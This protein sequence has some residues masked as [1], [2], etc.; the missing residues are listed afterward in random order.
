MT[1]RLI[2]A[3]VLASAVGGLGLATL[4]AHASTEDFNVCIGGDDQNR[5]GYTQKICVHD[6]VRKG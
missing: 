3:A 2:A 5:P 4:P 6:V 1:R